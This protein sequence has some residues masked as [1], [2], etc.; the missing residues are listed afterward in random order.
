MSGHLI[1]LALSL[2]HTHTHEAT[3]RQA[4]ALDNYH[5][6]YY[7]DGHCVLPPPPPQMDWDWE[8]Q[9]DALVGG[10]AGAGAGARGGIH[11]GAFPAMP[12]VE[13][14]ESSSSEASS[15][16]Y[17]Q[18][19]VAHWS[20]R[21]KRQRVVAEA[22]P[23]P[24]RP[25][26]ATNEDLYCLLQNFW[27]SGSSGEGRRLFHGLNIMIPECG[28]SFVS[29]EDDASGW[30]QGQGP[31]RGSGSAGVSGAGRRRG[32]PPPVHGSISSASSRTA[33]TATGQAAA[34]QLQLQKATSAG[35]A[36][37]AAQP[38]RRGNYSSCAQGKADRVVANKQERRQPPSSSRAAST[39]PRSSLTGK[40][41]KD[42]GVLYPF[43]V[44]KPLG[45]QGGGAATLNDVN[46]RILKRP[47]RPVRHPVGHFACSPAA[48]AHGLG[49]S[50]KAVVSLTRIRTAGK[51]TITIIRTRG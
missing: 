25:A 46:Q 29:G 11:E 32:S 20:D 5:C 41:K 47:A 40:E 48:Y 34:Q 12:G 43:A 13:S 15:G 14:P 8:L 6:S 26:A 38:G 42:I 28:G 39:S 24:R 44:V 2:S 35:A 9:F 49:L 23:P 22:A 30:E 51:G 3:R 10:D 36:H 21:C 4:M 18:D 50:G 1:S 27:D 31:E 16:A 19:A 17:L 33:T 45:L 37:A 7:D